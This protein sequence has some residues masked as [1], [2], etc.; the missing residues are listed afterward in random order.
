MSVVEWRAIDT[1]PWTLNPRT[2]KSSGPKALFLENDGGE[3]YVGQGDE[4][5]QSTRRG[6]VLKR[7]ITRQGS[8]APR[9]WPV[10]WATL[11]DNRLTGT[12]CT[13]GRT[14]TGGQA[15]KP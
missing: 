2:R 5:P 1:Y 11:P 14:G 15:S 13:P 12:P 6:R 9:K 8:I 4:V 10:A 7:T 3:V